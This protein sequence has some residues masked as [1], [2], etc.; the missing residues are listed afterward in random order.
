MSA[1]V[2]AVFHIRVPEVVDLDTYKLLLFV[3]L[4]KQI[5]LLSPI[6]TKGMRPVV[7]ARYCTVGLFSSGE[8]FHG[9]YVILC[10]NVP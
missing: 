2:N 1:F 10:L 4:D 8:L 6:R 5:A 9:I 3:E 7:E